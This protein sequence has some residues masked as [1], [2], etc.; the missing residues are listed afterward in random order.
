MIHGV[1]LIPYATC[2]KSI[3]KI[4]RLYTGGAHKTLGPNLL[5]IMAVVSLFT[6]Q[7]RLYFL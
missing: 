4:G 3:P 6:Y 2:V 7:G 1:P 5:V